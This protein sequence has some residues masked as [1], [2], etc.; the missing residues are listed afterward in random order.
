M[1]LS[2]HVPQNLLGEVRVVC[3]VSDVSVVGVVS[4]CEVQFRRL[5]VFWMD[6][7]S[8]VW[9]NRLV[10][11]CHLWYVVLEKGFVPVYGFLFHTLSWASICELWDSFPL[12]WRKD[13]SLHSES[14]IL[15]LNLCGFC[16]RT[17]KGDKWF[18]L[19]RRLNSL[20]ARHWYSRQSIWCF[21]LGNS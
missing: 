20:K 3:P 12:Y 18:N 7:W 8:F 1:F 2:P 17:Y 21:L 13:C 4:C 10:P 11:D 19:T 5:L 15:M 9:W 6:C 16:L 14:Q